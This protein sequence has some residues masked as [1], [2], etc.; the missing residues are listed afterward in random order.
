MSG[1]RGHV[2]GATAAALVTLAAPVRAACPSLARASPSERG[3]TLSAD[4]LYDAELRDARRAR[5]WRY[6]WTGINGALAV[7]SFGLLPLVQSEQRLELV[8]GGIG[9]TVA[10]V[11]TWFVPLEVEAT[12]DR[13]VALASACQ[14]L[15][16]EERFVAAAAADEASRVTWPWHLLNLGFGISYTLIVGLGADRWESGILDGVVAFGL[17]ELQLFTQPT[18]LARKWEAYGQKPG[19]GRTAWRVRALPG[20]REFAL[21]LQF[22][23]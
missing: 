2:V 17:G 6:A 22:A 18:G 1:C 10:A 13:K 12:L 20:R 23:F 7:G 4:W 11:F 21:T 9:S 3:A 16:V 14:R 19:L 8:V 15:A 5:T